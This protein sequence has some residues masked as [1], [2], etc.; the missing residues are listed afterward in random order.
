M[1]KRK[2]LPSKKR[3]IK[4]NKNRELTKK[5]KIEYNI[6]E[7]S[8][9]LIKMTQIEY[10]MYSKSDEIKTATFNLKISEDQLK[11]KDHGHGLQIQHSKDLNFNI[12]LKKRL[13]SFVLE[14]ST[15]FIAGNTELQSKKPIEKSLNSLI[16]D[17]W[18]K[19]KKVFQSSGQT[20]N[21]GDL[22]LAKMKSYSPWGAQV[23]SQTKNKKR[24]HVHFFGTNN[25][26][27]VDASEIV[28]FDL[29]SE[30]VRLLLLRKIGMFHK[31]I[32]EIES[33]LEVPPELSLLKECESLQ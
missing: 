7:C 6:K 3:E 28:T 31:S 26:G 33:I 23:K 14:N 22:V 4:L 27:T 2:K 18:K 16:N 1:A 29:C 20:I 11:I 24:V 13:S 12:T 32:R 25:E 10:E 19:C 17:S 30:V 5:S 8:V 15:E 21:V 9:N